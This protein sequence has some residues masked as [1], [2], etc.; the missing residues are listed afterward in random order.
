MPK[1]ASRSSKYVCWCDDCGGRNWRLKGEYA[2]HIGRSSPPKY[3]YI[4]VS[5][6]H[7]SYI[8]YADITHASGSL[9]MGV[10]ARKCSRHAKISR[11]VSLPCSASH[12]SRLSFCHRI[13]LIGRFGCL[14]FS[15]AENERQ[16][17]CYFCERSFES[18][19]RRTVH[20]RAKHQEY[21]WQCVDYSCGYRGYVIS[22]FLPLPAAKLGSVPESVIPWSPTF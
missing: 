13:A 17:S 11:L 20:F 6:V 14:L 1:P 21:L 9:P 4:A 15:G 5:R 16:F 10:Y 7:W 22:C 8:H 2:A 3:A 19:V 18:A 12:I